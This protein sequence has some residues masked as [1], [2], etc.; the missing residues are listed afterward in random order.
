MSCIKRRWSVCYFH[1]IE[2]AGVAQHTVLRSH[3][4]ID[5]NWH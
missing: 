2:G 5:D 1:G 3:L 4:Y